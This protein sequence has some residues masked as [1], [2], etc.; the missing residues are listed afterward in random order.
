MSNETD[1]KTLEGKRAAY[2]S[3]ENEGATDGFNPYEDEIA[4]KAEALM[5]E[6]KA[7]SPLLSDLAVEREWFNASKFTSAAVANTACLKRGYSLADLQ[8]AVKKIS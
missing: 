4:E 5:K 6:E 3:F 2:N 7:K 8:A 1:L